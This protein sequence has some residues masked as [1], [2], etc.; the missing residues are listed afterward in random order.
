MTFIWPELLWLL[1]IL[2]VLVLAYWS[3]L[4]RRKKVAIQYAGLATVR[5]AMRGSQF[6][7]HIPPLLFLLAIALMLLAVARPAAV[8]T[9]PSEHKTM[10]LAVDVSG[11][12]RATDVAPQPMSPPAVSP[13][14]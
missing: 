8:L 1:L 4:R 12:M 3:M 13:P 14:R 9:L 2:P 6:R 5:E 11:S 10:I 7:R